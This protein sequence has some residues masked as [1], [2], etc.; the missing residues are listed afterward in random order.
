MG[1]IMKER[2]EPPYLKYREKISIGQAD[3]EIA[4]EAVLSDAKKELVQE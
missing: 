1:L 3:N 4:S 2:L